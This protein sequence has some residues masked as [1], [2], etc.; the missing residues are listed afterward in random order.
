VLFDNGEFGF[1]LHHPKVEAFQIVLRNVVHALIVDDAVES[2]QIYLGEM[3]TVGVDCTSEL[4]TE[5]AA[6][7]EVVGP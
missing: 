2:S 5:T 1:V 4:K 3:G 6:N 7:R